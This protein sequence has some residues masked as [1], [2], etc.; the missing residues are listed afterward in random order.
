M[1]KNS[2]PGLRWQR[3][4]PDATV[5]YF[6]DFLPYKEADQLYTTLLREIPWRQD[7][8]KVFGKVYA[9]PRLTSLHSNSLST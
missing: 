8:V 9:Q 6:Q 1:A 2:S 5:R 7:D 3:D 4:L